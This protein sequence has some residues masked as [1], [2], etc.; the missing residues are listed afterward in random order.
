[1]QV[2]VLQLPRFLTHIEA[3]N[4]LNWKY[5]N[6]ISWVL[7]FPLFL[8]TR[9]Q[10]F[11]NQISLTWFRF[12]PWLGVGYFSKERWCP[13]ESSLQRIP[14]MFCCGN[15]TIR[16]LFFK[17]DLNAANLRPALEQGCGKQKPSA[18]KKNSERICYMFQVSK[19]RWDWDLGLCTFW[20]LAKRDLLR[21][22]KFPFFLR[23]KHVIFRRSP[24]HSISPNASTQKM[25][26]L[27]S[28]SIL[29]FDIRKM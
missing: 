28:Q 2:P 1:M 17:R 7:I 13:V 26:R 5:A 3:L 20:V 23:A 18:G 19:C 21:N 24:L 4:K 6:F 14:S 29:H 10:R 22:G 16:R 25:H 8:L 9:K 15:G 27:R 11:T 12:W